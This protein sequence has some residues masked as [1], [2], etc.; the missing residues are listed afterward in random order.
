MLL[1]MTVSA[2]TT[3][4]NF[5]RPALTVT[6]PAE[7]STVLAFMVTFAAAVIVRPDVSSF[8]ELPLLSSIVTWPGPS[9]S[10]ILLPARRLDDE[11]FLAVLIVERELYAV[12]RANDLAQIA[13]AG[14]RL[15]RASLPF[16]RPPTMI[17]KRGSSLTNVDQHFIADVGNQER[18]AIV[19]GEGAGDARPDRAVVLVHAV[20]IEDAH[21][22]ARELLGIVEVDHLRQDSRRKRGRASESQ[23][24]GRGR[25]HGLS[26]KG[27]FGGEIGFV[28]AREIEAVAA[29]GDVVG[30]AEA[31]AEP[32]ERDVRADAHRRIAFGGAIDR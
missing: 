6:M 3:P 27:A 10:V 30:V 25:A 9:L 7:T 4:L 11:L 18:A 24:G 19:P 5:E 15:G 20:E 13:P 23:K 2:C 28:T 26:E 8:T 1:Q 31:R 29:A 16:H 22:H 14:D 12:L 17:G 21:L 32:R